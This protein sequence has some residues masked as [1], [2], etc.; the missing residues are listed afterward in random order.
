LLTQGLKEKTFEQ[1]YYRITL[2]ADLRDDGGDGRGGYNFWADCLRQGVAAVNFDDNPQDPQVA[3]FTGLRPGDRL[4]A[5]LRNKTIGGLGTVTTP[6]DEQVAEE[7]PNEQDFFRGGMWLRVGVDWQPNEIS[8]DA[9]P[10]EVANLFLY[11]TLQELTAAQFAAVEQAINTTTPPPPP[12]PTIAREFQGFSADAFAFL[13]ELRANNN[14]AWMD[15]NRGRWQTSLFEPMRALFSDVGRVVKPLFDPYLAPDAL[16]TRATAHH[17][18]ARINKNWAAKVSGPYYDY[19]WGAFYRERLSRQT[20]AQLFANMWPEKLRF[21]FYLGEYAKLAYFRQR[22][23]NDPGSLYN[24]IVDLDLRN[25]FQFER[26]HP[27]GQREIIQITSADDLRQWIATGDYD[28]LQHL[29]PEETVRLGPALADRV[30]DVFRRVFPVYLWAVLDDPVP[31]VERYLAAEFPTDELEVEELESPPP[32]YTF[33]DFTAATHLT[34]EAAEELHDMLLEK[35]QV[36]F[37]GPPGTGKTYVAQ[38]LA[39]LMIG[40][41]E[42]PA[43]RLAIVQFHP[44]YGYEEFIEGIRPESVERSD[45]HQ[46]I[47]YPARPGIF[48]EFCRAAAQIGAPCIFIVDEINRG[49][50]PR[51]FGELML[52]LEYRGLEVRLPYSGKPFRIP[53]NVYLI[54]TMNTADRSI[55][56]V[57]FALRRRFHFAHFTADPGLFDRWLERQEAPLPYLGALYRRLAE[58]AIE[59]ANFAIGPSAFMRPGLNE[60]GLRRVWQ[61]SVMPYL[62]EYYLDQPAKAQR[63][64]WDGEL[65][66]GLRG[67]GHERG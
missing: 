40:L 8:V 4:V 48:V 53:P 41:A 21:G 7:R 16:E 52:L 12:G 33:A 42:P 19:Y 37:Y 27:D 3:K 24:L 13:T 26:T 47:S 31:A 39:R 35:R 10:K 38:A 14:K 5:F 63:W 56:L 65:L 29:S 51:I 6:Y 25:D 18:L 43:E 11:K 67:D 15:T 45:G 32:P 22:I 60:V 57:D 17:V 61:R 50:I 62:E 1:R 36:I 20:D 54:G 9:L 58:E 49:N 66:R 34:D 2:P 46:A 30:Y 23:Q 59:D 55:A 28:L 64:Q 44:A